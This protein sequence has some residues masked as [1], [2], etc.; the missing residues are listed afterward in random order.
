LL[1]AGAVAA[2]AMRRYTNFDLVFLLCMLFSIAGFTSIAYSSAQGAYEYYGDFHGNA[3]QTDDALRYADNG[4]VDALHAPFAAL[5]FTRLFHIEGKIANRVIGNAAETVIFLTIVNRAAALLVFFLIIRALV[6]PPLA[7]AAALLIFT[8]QYTN[9]GLTQSMK[10]V[11]G[12]PFFLLWILGYLR[13]RHARGGKWLALHTACLIPC[14]LSEQWII[15]FIGAFYLIMPLLRH[16]AGKSPDLLDLA[17]SAGVA[18]A[19]TALY[20]AEWH[21]F[22]HDLPFLFSLVPSMSRSPYMAEYATFVLFAALALA[23]GIIILRRSRPFPGMP[24]LALVIVPFV[25]F[26]RSLLFLYPILPTLMNADYMIFTFPYWLLISLALWRIV[27]DAFVAQRID[28]IAFLALAAWTI[29]S[30]PGFFLILGVAMPQSPVL[31]AVVTPLLVLAA[32]RGYGR[33]PHAALALTLVLI[34]LSIYK[35]AA[36]THAG[37]RLAILVPI[38]FCPVALALFRRRH[39]HA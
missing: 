25:I 1:S 38:L 33:I 19:A 10:F 5:P 39:R 29:G 26:Q 22:T 31:D 34:P 35:L 9:I 17:G 7:A 37:S 14:A 3:A 30:L 21:R 32:A 11:A 23:L 15:F 13:Y 8:F 12:W 6:A 28:N 20:F 2:T 16:A 24:M 18:C 36:Y 4:Y 27:R